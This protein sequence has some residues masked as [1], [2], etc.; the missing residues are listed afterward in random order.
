MVVMKTTPAA[1]L[2]AV[3]VPV[4]AGAYRND[5]D[6]RNELTH[7]SSDGG[8]EPLFKSCVKPGHLGDIYSVSEEETKARPTCPRCAK[9]WDRARG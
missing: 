8:G 1:I 2:A 4:L 9:A 3:T 6:S 7:L 5:D